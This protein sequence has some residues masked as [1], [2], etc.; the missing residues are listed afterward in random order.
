MRVKTIFWIIDYFERYFNLYFIFVCY[1][2]NV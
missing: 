1:R 2:I